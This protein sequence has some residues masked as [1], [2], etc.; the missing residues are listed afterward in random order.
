MANLPLTIK[1]H[2]NLS[3]DDAL[4]HLVHYIKIPFYL[5]YPV[6]HVFLYSYLLLVFFLKSAG[7]IF[8]VL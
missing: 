6:I 4:W 2:F 5:Y 8:T 1:S 3:I 7:E